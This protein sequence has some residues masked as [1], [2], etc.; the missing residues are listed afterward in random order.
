M[1]SATSV[2]KFEKNM[3]TKLEDMMEEV[4]TATLAAGETK[5]AVASAVGSPSTAL[6]VFHITYTFKWTVV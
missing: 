2:A 5:E 3:N 6:I 1:A 4:M